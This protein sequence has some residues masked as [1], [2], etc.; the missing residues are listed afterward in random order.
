M[1]Y[2]QDFG[3]GIHVHPLRPLVRLP[4]GGREVCMREREREREKERE[5]ER[6]RGRESERD[7]TLQFSDDIILSCENIALNLSHLTLV[8]LLQINTQLKILLKVKSTLVVSSYCII[9]P[10]FRIHMWQSQVENVLY[11]ITF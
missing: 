11:S 9:F 3:I 4:G 1:T 8:I 10:V 7:G 2:K 6:E 5:R